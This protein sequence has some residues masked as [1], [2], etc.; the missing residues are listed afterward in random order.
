MAFTMQEILD[1]CFSS[2]DDVAEL[3]N[4]PSMHCVDK[5][6]TQGKGTIYTDTAYRAL[7]VTGEHG[8][9]NVITC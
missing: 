8:I 1:E 6:A 4:E 7:L 5:F 3:F 9:D 2:E